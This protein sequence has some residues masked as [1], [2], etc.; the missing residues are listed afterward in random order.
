[1]ADGVDAVRSV[2]VA[3]S[4][5]TTLVPVAQIAGGVLPQG[6]A[7]PSI[8]I[9]SVSKDDRNIPSPGAYR[10][11]SERV[12]VTVLASTYPTQK[13]ILAAVRG[14]AADQINPTVTGLTRVTIHTESGGPDFM[15][16][17]ASIYLGTQDFICTYTETR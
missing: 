1:M 3:N 16:E 11:V 17:E 15:D 8:S 4:T 9:T 7:L 14:A 10:H 5:L 6:T 12:Q 2:L 13:S